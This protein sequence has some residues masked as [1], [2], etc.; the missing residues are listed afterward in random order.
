MPEP[1]K[2]I[3]IYICNDVQQDKKLSALKAYRAYGL[4]IIALSN[5]I[6]TSFE[7]K[8]KG[9]ETRVKEL[10]KALFMRGKQKIDQFLT[11]AEMIEPT[12]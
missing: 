3:Y 10:Q 11:S 12:F 8:N 5:V 7:C 2:Y 1:H 9:V 4:V 6:F